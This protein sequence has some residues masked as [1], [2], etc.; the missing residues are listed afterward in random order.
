MAE[1]LS[2][3]A[4]GLATVVESGGLS[5]VRVE[6]RRRLPATGFVWANDGLIVTSNHVVRQDAGIQVGLPDGATVPA[7]LIGRDASTDLALLRAEA[8]GLAAVTPADASS[9]RVGHLALA[10]GRPGRSVQATL[11]I[12]SAL[13]DSWRT[14]AGGTVDQYVQTDVV[15]YPGFS[16][17]PLVNVEGQTLGLNSSALARGVSVTLPIS[18]VARVV[19]GLAAHGKVRR[20][21]LGISTQ[22]ARLPQGWQEKLNRETGLLII[23]VE[24]DS[25][26]ERSGLVLGDTIVSFAGTPVRN[27]DDLLALLTGER[28]G[29]AAPA[30][31][32]RGGQ[33]QTLDVQIGER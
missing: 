1:T 5:V 11:G 29:K 8:T 7:A 6:A 30:E 18:T 27:H 3:L 4:E 19:D 25:P 31:L 10:L 12:I 16:G 9:M 33:L 20:G 26:A 14:G 2:K 32:L 13:G 17:G 24:S 28:V 22:A 23:A 15:M 21:Y